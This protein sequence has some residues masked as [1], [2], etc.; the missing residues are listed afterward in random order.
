MTVSRFVRISVLYEFPICWLLFVSDNGSQR[1]SNMKHVMASHKLFHSC[2]VAKLIHCFV[3]RKYLRLMK[4]LPSEYCLEIHNKWD[5]SK[6]GPAS[7][8]SNN[9]GVGRQA[10]SYLQQVG[11]SWDWA[12]LA[13]DQQSLAVMWP[14]C[15]YGDWVTVVCVAVTTSQGEQTDGYHRGWETEGLDIFPSP[16]ADAVDD[17]LPGTESV[18]CKTQGSQSDRYGCTTYRVKLE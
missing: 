16:Q 6:T 18:V 12:R 11:Y 9:S 7:L 2:F 8:T 15:C 5:V 4:Y 14:V 13:E 17:Y 3:I 10:L 1:D